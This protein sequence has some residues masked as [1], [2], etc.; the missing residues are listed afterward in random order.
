MWPVSRE[1]RRRLVGR[2]RVGCPVVSHDANKL[3][4]V[5]AVG[6]TKTK[7]T[8]RE[9]RK[10]RRSSIVGSFA[11]LLH[12]RYNLLYWY[13]TASPG[14][15][16][17]CQPKGD[18]LTDCASSLRRVDILHSCQKRGTTDKALGSNLTIVVDDSSKTS[19]QTTLCHRFSRKENCK[20]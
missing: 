13:Q 7:V 6:E 14:P 2:A 3:G 8:T 11:N 10:G 17:L 5:A 18:H 1:C 19:W 16:W 9:L 15:L 20:Q 4:Q 12:C